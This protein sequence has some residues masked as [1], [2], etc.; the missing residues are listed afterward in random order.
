MC[1]TNNTQD[2]WN[3]NQEIS[4]FS[5]KGKI[6]C[7]DVTDYT[8][9]ILNITEIDKTFFGYEKIEDTNWIGYW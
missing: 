5:N 4:Y 9:E 3:I 1:Y 2:V 6:T 8:A 7:Y